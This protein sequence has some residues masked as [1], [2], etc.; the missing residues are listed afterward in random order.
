MCMYFLWK[1][2][3]SPIHQEG[4]KEELKL[5]LNDLPSENEATDGKTAPEKE[6]KNA[7]KVSILFIF[8]I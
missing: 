4:A 1:K 8:E 7:F 3:S 5:P 6:S 2:K